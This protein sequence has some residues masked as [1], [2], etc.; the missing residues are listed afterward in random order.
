[1]NT[2]ISLKSRVISEA[3][4]A[5]LRRDD[6]GSSYFLSEQC[7]AAFDCRPD[8]IVVGKESLNHDLISRWPEAKLILLDTGLPQDEVITLFLSYKLVGVLSPDADTSLMKKALKV[9]HEG[10]IWIDNDILK[11]L[12]YKAGTISKS[13][14]IDNV[15]TREQ[16][17]LDQIALGRKNKEIAALLFISEQTVKA[18]LSRIFRKFNVSSRTQLLSHLNRI[19]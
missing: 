3:L 18:H 5:L 19:H 1:M 7:N 11:A 6:D 8:V 12:L 17:I 2:L 10:K 4:Y 16:Q 13:G 14:R 9:V 15:S